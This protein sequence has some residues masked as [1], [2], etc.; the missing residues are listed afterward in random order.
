MEYGPP[1]PQS[2]LFGMDALADTA[3]DNWLTVNVFTPDLGGN[4]PVMVW[5]QGGGYMFGTSG[6]PEYDGNRLALD[7]VVL[8]TFNYRTGIE[9]FAQFAGAPANRGLLDQVAALEWVRDNIAAFG[10]DPGQV[11][12]FGESAGGGSVACLLAMPRANGLF[13][14]AIVQSMPG[15]FFTPNWPRTS[16][17]SSPPNWDYGRPCRTWRPWLRR[18]CRRWGTRSWRR[19]GS[20]PTGGGWPRTGRSRSPRSSTGTCCRQPRGRPSKRVRPAAST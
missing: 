10:G 5:I 1:P 17:G 15:A 14:R 7:G 11:T 16:L 12:V 2:G 8:V 9:G 20:G 4:L 3:D 18:S 13:H 19:S 6:L